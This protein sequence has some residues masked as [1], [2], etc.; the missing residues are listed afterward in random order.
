MLCEP[1]YW[2]NEFLEAHASFVY[3]LAKR[4][5]CNDAATA[6]Y[7]GAPSWCDRIITVEIGTYGVWGE[8]HSDIVWP[9]AEVKRNTLRALIQH[10]WSAFDNYARSARKPMP[11]FEISCVG[12]T[13]GADIYLNQDP[14]CCRYAVENLGFHMVRKFIGADPYKF[15][16]GDEEQFIENNVGRRRLRLEWG[17]ATGEISQEAFGGMGGV[18]DTV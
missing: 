11:E 5:Y 6:G 17:S 8:W 12:S 14:Q 9:S 18:P 3:A 16:R 4:F 1:F 7:S 15:L 10:F 13:V 2:S